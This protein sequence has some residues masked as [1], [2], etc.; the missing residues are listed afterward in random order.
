MTPYG[1]TVGHFLFAAH[2]GM[3]DQYSGLLQFAAFNARTQ[4]VEIKAV[5]NQDPAAF[6]AGEPVGDNATTQTYYRRAPWL[7]RGIQLRANAVSAMPFRIM[8]G[9]TEVDNSE[10]WQNKVGF[11]P[12]PARLLWL[13][14]AALCLWGTAY[15]WRD[16]NRAKALGLRYIVPSTIEPQLDDARGLIGFVR[17]I[18][19]RRI[20]ATLDDIVYFWQ[21][22]PYVEIGAPN[23]SPAMAA[24]SAAG[25]LYNIDAFAEAFFKRGAIKATLLTVEGNPANE[26]KSRLKE[27]WA[28]A[29]GGINNAFNANVF[30]GAVKPVTVGEGLESLSDSVLTADKR[31][32]VAT[33][34]GIP[35]TVLFSADA[36]GLGGGGV[37]RQDDVHFYDKTIVPECRYIAGELN[38]QVFEPLGLRIDFLP[39]T[40]DVFQADENNRAASFAA[41][42]GAG[43][44]KSLVAEMLG[45]ELPAGWEYA[46]LDPEEPEPQPMAAPS[47]P[48][49]PGQAG[50]AGQEAQPGDDINAQV[51]AIVAGVTREGKSELYQWRRW[52]AKRA[53]GDL[54]GFHVNGHLPERVIEAVK[55]DLAQAHTREDVSAAFAPWL[56][57]P[58]MPAAPTA[59]Q[60]DAL[61]DALRALTEALLHA[62]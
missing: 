5:S 62:E 28:R 48:G 2:T 19:P 6:L 55:A 39:E 59:P 22:D 15:Y 58:D 34:L 56:D 51:D 30:S 61:A 53:G 43:L 41:Y 21:P 9:G 24:M 16:R 31:A 1:I 32:D 3:P 36:S 42:V 46:D 57:A 40:L 45:L 13:T 47:E 54:S 17:T 7:F 44:P 49:Q 23:S 26:E 60:A 37:V 11:L 12:D 33:A 27:W 29:I 18:G 4:R 25:V 20:P 52:A 14:E 8:R 10:T 50:Q 35:Q 38:E